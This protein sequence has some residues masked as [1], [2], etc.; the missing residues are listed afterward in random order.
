[1]GGWGGGAGAPAPPP[2]RRWLSLDAGPVFSLESLD[3]WDEMIGRAS[4]LGFTDVVTHWPRTEGPYAGRLTVLDQV[5]D[6]IAASRAEPSDQQSR[7][8]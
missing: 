1:A 2:L 7:Q 8:P 6:R 4:E 5:A 3:V